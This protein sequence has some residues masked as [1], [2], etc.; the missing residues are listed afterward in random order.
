MFPLSSVKDARLVI[1]RFAAWRTFRQYS[2]S[3]VVPAG[4]KTRIMQNDSQFPLTVVLQADV[5]TTAGFAPQV[6]PTAGS[7][8]IL[9]E[10]KGTT[11]GKGTVVVLKPNEELWVTSLVNDT[12]RVWE[13]RA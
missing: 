5:G 9:S 7:N 12:Y 8:L 3:V 13:I 6:D 2:R 4:V 1:Q 10:I 11:D